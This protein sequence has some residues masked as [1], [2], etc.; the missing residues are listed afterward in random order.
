MKVKEISDPVKSEF[1]YHI[2]KVEEIKEAEPVDKLDPQALN[3][4]KRAVLNNRVEKLKSAAKI[5]M[6]KDGLK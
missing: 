3:G 1:G 2:I 4:I 5:V 6:N